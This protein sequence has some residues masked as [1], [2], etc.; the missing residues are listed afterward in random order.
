MYCDDKNFN[1]GFKTQKTTFNIAL[2][3]YKY[4]VYASSFSLATQKSR[5]V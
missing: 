5:L 3:Y 4:A 1:N 2:K